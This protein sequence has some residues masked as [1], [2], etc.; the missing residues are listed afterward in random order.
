MTEGLIYTLGLVSLIILT[1]THWFDPFLVHKGSPRR[2]RLVLIIFF[3]LLLVT[4][5]LYLPVIP[6][7]AVNLSGIIIPVIV[8]LVRLW[9]FP[10][11]QM[12]QMGAV[13]LFLA[14]FYA[15]SY[16]VL[17]MDPILMI[18]SPRYLFPIVFT[19]MILLVTKEWPSI[20]FLMASGMIGGEL[21]HQGF[22]LEHAVLVQVGDGAFRDQL[23]L[24]LVM[25]SVSSIS[26]S[27]LV[28]A[29]Q[30]IKKVFADKEKSVT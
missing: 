17:L 25:V 21:L 24:G 11:G 16:Q 14:L 3:S 4:Q 20:W 26:L 1:A 9:R 10:P 19:L 13:I 23:L 29:G 2:Y 8:C 6:G 22:L 5:G 7:Y 15:V 28:K 12:W 30:V 27:F 18:I